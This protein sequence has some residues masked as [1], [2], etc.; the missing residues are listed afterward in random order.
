MKL[1]EDHGFLI[2]TPLFM[3]EHNQLFNTLAAMTFD[4]LQTLYKCSQK[5][6]MPVWEEQ[7]RQKQGIFPPASPA[8]LSYSGIAYQS[9]APDVF[10]DAQWAYIN[11]HLRIIS[12]MYGLLRPLD[13]IVP[14]RLEMQ[15]RIPMQL[16][17]FWGKKI[18]NALDDDVVIN[19]ASKE[20]SRCV[21]TFQPVITPRFFELEDGKRKEKGV[22]VKIARG[23]MVRWMAE[24]QIQDPKDL[25]HFHELGYGYDPQ[26]S[27]QTVLHFVRKEGYHA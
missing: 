17:E 18:V 7:E 6:M 15:Q 19:L 13:G 10:D 8:L 23:A 16:Y 25:V 9:M 4:Q 2:S 24:N 20:Y 3:N 26:T 27:T 14:Y 5:T 12:A 22:Y 21:E 1:C 11:E